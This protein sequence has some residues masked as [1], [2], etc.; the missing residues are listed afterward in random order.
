MKVIKLQGQYEKQKGI[1]YEYDAHSTPLGEGGMGIVYRGRCVEERTG[2][3]K[4]VAIK[5]LHPNL[6]QEVYTRAEREASIRIKHDNLVEMLGFISVFE[7]NRLAEPTYRHYVI[8]EYLNGIELSDLLVGR[9]DGI[10]NNNG[11][12]VRD[13]YSKYIK[14]REAISLHIIR[15]VLSGVLALHDK[16][17]IHRD[18]DPGNIMVTADGCIKLIDFGIAKKLNSLGTSDKLMT[19]TG[20]F[21]GKAEYASPELVYGD[22]KSQNYTTDIYALGILFYRLLVGRLPFDGTQY[23]VLECQKG[24]KV[25]V[26]N[27]GNK[28][29]ARI[30]KKA[31]EKQQ[32]RRYGSI[33][34][35]RVAID[36]AEKARPNI[37][38][39]AFKVVAALTLIVALVFGMKIVLEHQPTI[40]Q[41][42]CRFQ[43]ALNKLD[44]SN[45]DSVKVG[46][47]Q[48]KA[49]ADKGNDTAKVE[50][51][52]TYF[53]NPNND[54]ITHRRELLGK[55]TGGNRQPNE[56]D[57]VIKY[58]SSIE[59]MNVLSPEVYYILGCA[60]YFSHD[61]SN[62]LSS[63]EK[64]L[65][66]LNLNIS[67]AHGYNNMELKTI[68]E[69][70]IELLKQ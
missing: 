44:S 25:P 69:D 31:T 67:A 37:L 32:N 63:F 48:M 59:D 21:I 13:L 1:Y 20:I 68:L 45:P 6:P 55:D 58:I 5:A 40:H 22:V 64:S 14:D 2:N 12:F 7:T 38:K 17:Y 54:I 62:A 27:I 35:F 18:I 60:Y 34:E 16:G 8:S 53:S 46:F 43:D 24:K 9:F 47:K 39:K 51:G 61:N 56:L 10:K 33:A 30:V 65:A 3:S 50:I 66:L 70:N 36:A 49:I 57:L 4:E 11:E 29:Y 42:T 26:K 28:E 41:E 52:I 19:A 15:N 23:E